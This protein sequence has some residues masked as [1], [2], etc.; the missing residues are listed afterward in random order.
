[1]STEVKLEEGPGLEAEEDEV[2]TE[3]EEV[4]RRVRLRR[5]IIWTSANHTG[6]AL[7]AHPELF[8]MT[9]RKIFF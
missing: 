8:L 9:C 1:M 7:L 4:P 5:R 6:L 3:A 2:E